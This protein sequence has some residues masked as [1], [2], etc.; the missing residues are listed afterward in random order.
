M[1]YF[2]AQSSADLFRNPVLGATHK[3]CHFE[4]RVIVHG[5]WLMAVAHAR[6]MASCKACSYLL[7]GLLN[8]HLHVVRQELPSREAVREVVRVADGHWAQSP[9]TFIA[10]H[11]AYGALAGACTL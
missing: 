5:S 4:K 8:P 10:I 2:L 9:H 7:R 6:C 3:P 11:C 1:V